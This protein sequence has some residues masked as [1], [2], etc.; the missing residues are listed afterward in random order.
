[1]TTQVAPPAW[2]SSISVSILSLT[3]CSMRLSAAS[4]ATTVGA[5]SI[6]VAIAIKAGWDVVVSS[7]SATVSAVRSAAVVPPERVAGGTQPGSRP[8]TH[9][10]PDLDS[11]SLPNE[12]GRAAGGCADANED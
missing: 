7:M 12:E 2:A 8:H 1:M 3:I 5:L 11:W 4:R 6:A 10:A 9:L